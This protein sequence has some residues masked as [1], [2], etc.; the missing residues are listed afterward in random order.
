MSL[1][2]RVA[3]VTGGGRGI[4]KAIALALA[5]DGADIAIVYRKDKD[6]A[7]ATADT[8]TAIGRKARA[9]QA[10]VDDLAA[11]TNAVARIA[12]EL[13]P[14]G[15]LINNAGISS[16]GNSVAETDPAEIARVVGVH[17]FGAFYCS[18]L[19]LPMMRKLG[20]G[21]IIMISSIASRNWPALGAP[22]NMG[23]AALE[24][25][26]FTLAQEE[27]NNNIRVNIVAA[28][29]T[30]T[31]MGTKLAQAA[32]GVKS[33]IH[34]LDAKMPFGRVSGPE[35]VANLVRFLVSDRNSYVSGQRIYVDGAL[36]A[37]DP[38]RA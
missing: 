30:A 2:G 1:K 5:E 6:S 4:G 19:V 21:D 12:E 23:K 8:I 24:A 10:P 11:V 13:G 18:R 31:E 17:A 37:W 32:F 33:D 27:R 3:L 15:I 16:R 22:Y 14:I 20:R 25:L 29:L 34:E 7:Q 28:G 35:D 26:G 36:W 9:Y 38:T